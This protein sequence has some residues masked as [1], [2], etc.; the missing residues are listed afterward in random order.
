MHVLVSLANSALDI[1][2][3]ATSLM[4]LHVFDSEVKHFKK[5]DI[6]LG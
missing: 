1:H 2:D 3:Q 6:R 5:G 4:A